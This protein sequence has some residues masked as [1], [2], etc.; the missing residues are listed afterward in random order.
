MCRIYSSTPPE[1]YA[2]RTKSVR[3]NGAVTSIRLEQRFWSILEQLVQDEGTT[4]GKFL[5]SL[6]DE[7]MNA[8]GHI[9]NFTSLLRVACTT[10]LVNR[11]VPAGAIVRAAHGDPAMDASPQTKRH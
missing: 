2:S 11:P 8:Q 6:Y 5:S 3:L 7:A 1:E 9:D 10:Y 4:L